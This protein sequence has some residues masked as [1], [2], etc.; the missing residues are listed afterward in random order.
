VLATLAAPAG[1]APGSAHSGR[2]EAEV[3][4]RRGQNPL[5]QTLTVRLYFALDRHPLTGFSPVLTAT[6]PAETAGPTRLVETKKPGVYRGV[7]VFPTA[8]RWTLDIRAGL[9]VAT[10]PFDLD[11]S[12]AAWASPPATAHATQKEI[13]P[14]RSVVFAVAVA[15][16]VLLVGAFIALA[17]L[18]RQRNKLT[19]SLPP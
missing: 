12:G 13:G 17:L 11:S 3:S 5:E 15:G 7:I 18:R 19:Q 6:G 9:F 2:I 8:G 4:A 10:V 14:R 16:A 1:A